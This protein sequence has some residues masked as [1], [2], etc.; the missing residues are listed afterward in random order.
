MPG[1]KAGAQKAKQKL[2]NKLGGY[3]K[4]M[5]WM[6]GIGSKGG[7]NGFGPDYTG[8]FAGN[9]ALASTAGRK[10]GLISR[11]RPKAVKD[12]NDVMES[13]IVG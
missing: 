13:G 2:I 12:F 9:R 5:E 8:G 10:G 7:H 4:Y 6:K 3:D 1:T 11:R